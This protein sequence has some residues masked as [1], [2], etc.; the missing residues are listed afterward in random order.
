MTPKQKAEAEPFPNFPELPPV[1]KAP[2]PPK[3]VSNVVYAANQI[4][5]IIEEQDPY[6]VVGGSIPRL[7]KQP[8]QPVAPTYEKDMHP[9][10]PPVP[11]TPKS[12]LD[13]AIE[14]AKKGAIFKYEGKQISSDNAIDLLKKNKDLNIDSRSKNGTQTIRITKEPIFIDWF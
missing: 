8:N 11:P 4:D 10:S 12:P 7:P 1:P 9:N 13:F 5:S 3:N 6:D 2:K 14:M